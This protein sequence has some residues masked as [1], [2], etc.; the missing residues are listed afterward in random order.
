[1]A[2][3]DRSDAAHAHAP[4][5][6]ARELPA[7]ARADG[8]ELWGEQRSSG[9]RRPPLLV[10]RAD[11]QVIQMTPVLY[12]VLES[13]DGRSG[14]HDIAAS[15]SRRIGKEATVEDVRFL[16]EEK[17]RPLGVLH[18]PDAAPASLQR[19]EPIARSPRPGCRRPAVAH[20][21]AGSAARPTLLASGAAF[22]ARAVRGDRGWLFF[23]NGLAGPVRDAI[24]QPGLLLAVIGLTVASAAFHEL[25]HAAACRY[26]GATP[27]VMGAGIYMVWPAFYTDVTDSYRLDRRGRL[28]RR[29]RRHLLQ[30]RLRCRHRRA[31]VAHGLGRASIVVPLQLM[32]MLRQLVPLVRLDGYHILADLIGVPDLFA[33]LKP[34]LLGLLPTRWGRPESRVLRPWARVVVTVWVVLVVPVLVLSLVMAVVMFPR[35]ASTGWDSLQQQWAGLRGAWSDADAAGVGAGVVSMFAVALPILCIPYLVTRIGRRAG[36]S[37]WRATSDRPGLRTLVV[38]VAAGLL[39]MLAA[40]WW[41]DGQYEPINRSER[42]AVQDGLVIELASIAPAVFDS[43]AGFDSPAATPET[44]RRVEGVVVDPLRSA[45]DPRRSAVD[46]RRRPSG[47][48]RTAGRVAARG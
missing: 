32:Q 1:M 6:E 18:A 25:G 45:V 21:P 31:L 11:G 15:V 38:L 27:G 5:D 34:V 26:G 23:V 46:H 12:R 28:P 42:G 24:Y 35:L 47:C 13:I 17:L 7:P 44:D 8:L 48:R 40:V 43:P 41:P 3:V 4:V 33:H 9:H 37:V 30:R 22:D 16:A 29:P 39:S 10:K 20:A 19:A 2:I 14:Y 36:R